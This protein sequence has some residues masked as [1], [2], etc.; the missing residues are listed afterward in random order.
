MYLHNIAIFFSISFFYS[1][2]VAESAKI[3]GIFP[4][5]SRS[6]HSINQPIVK[7]LAYKGHQVTVISPFKS[8]DNV[9][10]YREILLSQ[11]VELPD[12]VDTITIEDSVNFIGARQIMKMSGYL[13]SSNCDKVLGLEYVKQLIHSNDKNN[14]IDLIMAEVYHVQCIHLLAY[15]LNVPLILVHPLSTAM[16]TDYFVG[17]PVVLSTTP[18]GYS[19]FTTKM[20]FWQRLENVF[21]YAV[22]YWCHNFVHNKDMAVYARKHFNMELP[23][24]EELHRRTALVFYDNHPSFISRSK[25]PNVIDIAGLHIKDPKKLPK[26]VA[27][28]IEGAA[29]GVIFFSFGTTIK[30]SS[31]SSEKLLAIKSAFSAVP[32]RVLWRVNDLNLTDVP[33]NVKLGKW[34]PQRDVLEHKNVI[35]FIS[36]CGLQGT[37]EAIHTATPVIAIPI[38][39]DQFQNAKVL[40]ER[41][42]G[43]EVDYFEMNKDTLIGAI[44]EITSNT[45]YQENV[46]RWSNIFKDRPV[47]ALDEALYWTE[48]VIKH[49]GAPHLRT[50][51]ADT[52]FYQYLLLDVL[53]LLLLVVICFLYLSKLFF[54]C[55]ISLVYRQKSKKNKTQ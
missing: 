33:P 35:A 50:A 2:P 14:Q 32:Q 38:A 54:K 19:A 10:N 42:V 4:I 18:M 43:I 23:S 46:I 37:L 28:F 20:N 3:L 25:S 39:F 34:F 55:I 40:V 6:H 8:N 17:N 7:G 26:D 44:K 11:I 52:P 53:G 29:H 45:K 47:S 21:E 24:D 1:N 12:W 31:I 5:Q 48:Y 36:H 16:G 41:E 49:R 15:K 22:E 51:A 13:E 27:E 30:A 9:P